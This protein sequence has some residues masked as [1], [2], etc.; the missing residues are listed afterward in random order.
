MSNEQTDG[1]NKEA[2]VLEAFYNGED[3]YHEEHR[4]SRNRREEEAD[5]KHDALQSTPSWRE[6]LL[7]R[8]SRVGGAD[9][10]PAGVPPLSGR[11][12]D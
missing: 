9:G 3:R 10:G 5:K 2:D 6:M 4:P 11:I 1:E 8:Q 12:A 7:Q